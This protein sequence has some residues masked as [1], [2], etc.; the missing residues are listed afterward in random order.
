MNINK[1]IKKITSRLQSLFGITRSELIISTLILS[2]LI[3]S[4]VNRLV[5]GNDESLTF[6][7]KLSADL[8][9]ALDSL[10]EA[11]RTTFIG[12]QLGGGADSTLVL[13]DTVVKPDFTYSS[14]GKKLPPK[15][16][17]KISTDSIQKLILLP[18][19]GEGTARKIIAYRKHHRFRTIHDIMRVRG[20]GPKKFAKM[21][22]YIVL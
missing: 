5:F 19:I 8:Y 1:Q 10:A 13:G 2:A 18:G 16:K 7:K 9:R 6:N 12:S 4:T 15:E 21:K 11:N 3:I 17:I 22:E 20:I 14:R